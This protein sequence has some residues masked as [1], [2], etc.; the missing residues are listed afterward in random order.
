MPE[1]KP[2]A[3]AIDGGDGKSWRLPLESLSA[4]SLEAHSPGE[5]PE[6]DRLQVGGCPRLLGW[7][8]SLQPGWWGQEAHATT[9]SPRLPLTL[10]HAAAR[11]LFRGP[12]AAARLVQ[13]RE[14]VTKFCLRGAPG[15]KRGP[16]PVSAP[17]CDPTAVPALEH[18]PAADAGGRREGLGRTGRGTEGPGGEGRGRIAYQR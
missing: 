16:R 13:N 2:F 10:P 15:G 18:L 14:A 4:T 17:L 5:Q 1:A 6:I 3:D 11:P 9:L 12:Q 8:H 7:A